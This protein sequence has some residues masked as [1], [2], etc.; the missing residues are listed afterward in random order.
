MEKLN[1]I[2]KNLN[3]IYY[4][5]FKENHKGKLNFNFPQDYFRWDMIEYLI[6]KNNYKKY[7]EIGCDQNQLFSRINIQNKVGVDPA[8]G[9]N[10]R[11]TSDNFFE[12][13]KDMFDIIFI[14]GLHIYEQVKKD[15]LNSIK[16]L[17]DEGVILIHDCLPDSMAKQAVPRYEMQWNGDVWKAIVDLRRNTEL[18]IFTCEIDQGIGIIKKNKNTS[19]LKIDKPIEK[20]KFE[21]YY[22]NY[23]NYMR[24]ISLEE[25]KKKF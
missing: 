12:K 9:G 23:K 20:L 2:K 13:N 3:K 24:I 21:D 17:N 15:I 22:E 1:K 16:Y 18:E 11:E 10:V 14:D 6:K 25:F 4:L 19:I 5:L 7:L 8:S